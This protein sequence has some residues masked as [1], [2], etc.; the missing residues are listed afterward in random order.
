LDDR[1]D[2]IIPFLCS[3]S[4]ALR[5]YKEYDMSSYIRSSRI[6]NGA[7]S[8]AVKSLSPK[9]YRR[10]LSINPQLNLCYWCE[11]EM[12]EPPKAIYMSMPVHSCGAM[13]NKSGAV[14]VC[15]RCSRFKKYIVQ[16]Y[17]AKMRHRATQN[18]T[19]MGG[20]V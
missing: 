16:E 12:L 4:R 19:D 8:V 1:T 17:V 9:R 5:T 6:S 10:V 3:C 7:L 2:S 20:L 11:V 15:K 13:D 18:R 14:L